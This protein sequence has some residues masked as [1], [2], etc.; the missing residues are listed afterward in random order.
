M[1]LNNAF[2]K[3]E[4]LRAARPDGTEI[5][6]HINNSFPSQCVPMGGSLLLAWL[7]LAWWLSELQ[8][9]LTVSFLVPKTFPFCCVKTL[10]PAEKM[11]SHCMEYVI[12]QDQDSD[13]KRTR[14]AMML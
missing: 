2:L 5:K 6:N 10:V 7:Y 14:P 1:N 13:L 11:P 9:T 3:E 8:H 4:E 12:V